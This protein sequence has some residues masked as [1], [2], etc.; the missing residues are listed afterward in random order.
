MA[1]SARELVGAHGQ[2]WPAAVSHRFL[3]DCK[4]GTIGENQFDAWLVQVGSSSGFGSADRRRRGAPA[5]AAP[6]PA[7]SFSLTAPLCRPLQTPSTPHFPSLRLQDFYFARGFVRFSAALLAK[8]PPEAFD[9]LL[10]GM[11][12]LQ[13]ELRWFQVGAEGGGRRPCG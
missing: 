12:A 4:A 13:D 2:A 9:L 7:A 11:A 10:G 5:T 1:S 6:A 3:E 8:A